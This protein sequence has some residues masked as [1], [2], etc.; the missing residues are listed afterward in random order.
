MQY[1]IAESLFDSV[2]SKLVRIAKKC[3]RYGGGFTFDIVGEEY[4][5][6]TNSAHVHETQKFIIIDVSG[7]A[8]IDDWEFVATLDIYKNGNIVR[9]YNTDIDLPN[10]FMK[11]EN[12]C[13]HCGTK[14]LRNNLYVI[15]NTETGEF[16]QVGGNCL[17]LYTGGLSMEYVAAW[18]DGI[19]ELESNSCVFGSKVYYDVRDVV[20]YA[21]IITEK[22]GYMRASDNPSL[23]ATRDMVRIVSNK[24]EGAVDELNA[25]LREHGYEEKFT[26]SDFTADVDEVVDAIIDYWFRCEDGGEFAHNVKVMLEEGYVES[27][28]FG[29]LAYLPKGYMRH[30]EREA[31]HVKN[32]SEP[33][34]YYGEVSKR[35][36]NIDVE[37]VEK[38]A[39]FETDY[40]IS[41]IYAITICD[42]SRLVWKTTKYIEDGCSK[43]S[44]T[45]KSHGEYRGKMQTEVTR[46][47]IS[48]N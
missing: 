33:C 31:E 15:H 39:S 24:H 19:T 30:V 27:K 34:S 37:R 38:I 41:H 20:R 25:K 32:T 12:V 3:V 16:R 22:V 11:S 28:Q 9:R 36:K 40:G 17:A 43:I 42:G 13:E 10:R 7:T 4:R 45:V 23:L 26:I 47:S 2:S 29:Y 44:F 18:M 1:A 14:R 8:K 46:C 21:Y 48:Y 6:Y 5:S 35:Y